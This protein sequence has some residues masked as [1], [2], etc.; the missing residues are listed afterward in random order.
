MYGVLRTELPGQVQP[1]GRGLVEEHGEG[2]AEHLAGAPRGP[3]A[4][5]VAGSGLSW[6]RS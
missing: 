1:L 3:E 5:A 4:E 6:S 2:V